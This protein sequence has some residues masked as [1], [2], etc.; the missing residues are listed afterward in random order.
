M[1]FLQYNHDTWSSYKWLKSLPPKWA[2][3]ENLSAQWAIFDLTFV[4]PFGC[5]CMCLLMTNMGCYSIYQGWAEISIM[6]PRNV[7]VYVS[8]QGQDDCRC[9][10]TCRGVLMNSKWL[11]L[12]YSN[13]AVELQWHPAT[14]G[15]M[16]GIP[17]DQNCSKW[18]STG[19]IWNLAYWIS[20][21][22]LY[23]DIFH[24]HLSYE[25]V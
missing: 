4:N 10:A 9:Q 13:A 14:A 18:R 7:R 16:V 15:S 17:A 8:H 24:T 1:L 20:D 6:W 19:N 5:P 12:C 22:L 23:W 25:Q 21:N 2:Y 3:V 11:C